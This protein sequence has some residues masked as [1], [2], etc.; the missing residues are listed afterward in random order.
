[1]EDVYKKVVC[2][3]I[4]LQDIVLV[5][6]VKLYQLYIDVNSTILSPWKR[7]RYKLKMIR[8]VETRPSDSTDH[9]ALSQV[10]TV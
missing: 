9:G 4:Q 3:F 10:K 7:N 8:L 1:M 2:K 5:N 6:A